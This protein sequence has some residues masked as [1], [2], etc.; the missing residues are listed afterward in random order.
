MKQTLLLCIFLLF[1]TSVVG[2]RYTG[3]EITYEHIGTSTQPY[4]YKIKLSM[5]RPYQAGVVKY[6]TTMPINISSSCFGSTTVDLKRV[7][8]TAAQAAGDG[9]FALMRAYQ[10]IDTSDTNVLHISIHKYEDTLTLPGTCS[11]YRFSYMGCCRDTG[12]ANYLTPTSDTLYLEATLNHTH[13][14]LTPNS[15]ANFD[16]AP[17]VNLCLNNDT[18]LSFGATDPNGDSLHYEITRPETAKN[19]YLNWG[20]G[21]ADHNPVQNINGFSFN[22]RNGIMQFDPAISEKD[23][24]KVKVTEYHYGHFFPLFYPIGSTTREIVLNIMPSCKTPSPTPLFNSTAANIDTSARF[25]CNDSIIK[26]KLKQEIRVSSLDKNGSNFRLINTR[27]NNSIPIISANTISTKYSGLYTKEI[28]LKTFNP[29]SRNDTF[30]L[31][32]KP[33][34]QGTKLITSCEHEFTSGTVRLV[35][36]DC[37]PVFGIHENEVENEILAYPNPLGKTLILQLPNGSFEG[38]ATI[39][40]YDLSGKQME[41]VYLHPIN[42]NTI[43]LNCGHLR[44]GVYLVQL[45]QPNQNPHVIK[46]IKE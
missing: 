15:S 24:L 7:A 19:A 41:T 33:G 30:D 6:D 32:I 14:T 16:A 4:L 22:Q 13:N 26:L 20:V 21:Y 39:S 29:I 42:A 12:L 34:L 44:P 25:Y 1:T 10:C 36:D 45:N 18:P 38:T 3:G 5:Y 40:I 17:L 43:Q 23:A 46:I 9:G 37:L 27:N 11:D 28:W 35:V 8:P 31:S 2:Q